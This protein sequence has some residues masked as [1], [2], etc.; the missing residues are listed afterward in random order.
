MLIDDGRGRASDYADLPSIARAVQAQYPNG[1]G[2]L[3]VIPPD[4]V[5]PSDEVRSTINHTLVE[6]EQSI[7]CVCWLIEGAGFQAA[8][9]RAVLTGMRFLTRAAYTRHVSVDLQHALTWMLSQLAAGPQRMTD[10]PVAA[11]F[12]RSAL[13]KIELIRRAD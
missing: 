8:M 1:F 10:V 11:E 6:V 12:V 9:V 2:V 3:I 4:A 5:P 7:R 13:A